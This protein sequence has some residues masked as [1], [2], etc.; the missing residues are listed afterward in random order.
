M[1]IFAVLPGRFQGSPEISMSVAHC[2][3][4]GQAPSKLTLEPLS[5]AGDRLPKLSE[6]R[7]SA[8]PS[9][10]GQLEPKR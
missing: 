1:A 4:D 7:R 10:D 6:P 8:Y 5:G 2:E 9:R 3:L